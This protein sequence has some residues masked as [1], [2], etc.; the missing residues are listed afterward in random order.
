METASC[1]PVMST[2]TWFVAS[3]VTVII[4]LS[5]GSPGVGKIMS[6]ADKLLRLKIEP[7]IVFTGLAL[8]DLVV[9]D[10]CAPADPAPLEG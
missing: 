9:G 7:T 10:D 2:I 6:I 5:A 4:N 3:A 1:A 8:A